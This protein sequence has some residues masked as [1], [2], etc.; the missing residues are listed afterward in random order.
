MSYCPCL[1]DESFPSEH[2][3]VLCRL[4]KLPFPPH[5]LFY[6]LKLK[7]TRIQYLYNFWDLLFGEEGGGRGDAEQPQQGG[8]CL[9]ICPLECSSMGRPEQAGTT[10]QAF[11]RRKSIS[12]APYG[13]HESSW[14]QSEWVRLPEDRWGHRL[15]ENQAASLVLT[16]LGFCVQ[17]PKTQ[18]NP[19][20]LILWTFRSVGNWVKS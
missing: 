3:T 8:S 7:S 16:F 10:M 6:C 2:G 1:L 18:G 19:N 13:K 4:P 20:F 11:S 17:R 12:C 15:S 5:L 9:H 14:I